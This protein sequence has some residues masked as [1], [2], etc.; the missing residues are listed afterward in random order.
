MLLTLDFDSDNPD[1]PV[2]GIRDFPEEG[3]S[4]LF[5]FDEGDTLNSLR[6]WAPGGGFSAVATG[7]TGQDA[8]SFLTNGGIHLQATSYVPLGPEID[9]T[10]PYTIF[11]HGS[12]DLPIQ[13]DGVTT[14]VSGMLSTDQYPARGFILYTT[15]GTSYPDDASGQ[16]LALRHTV[17]GVQQAPGGPWLI[18]GLTYLDP[19]TMA[20]RFDGTTA[21]LRVYR[22]GTL[23]ANFAQGI[24]V[25]GYTTNSSSVQDKTMRPV[26]GSPSTVFREGNLSAEISGVYTRALTDAELV[27]LDLAA[28]SLRHA[29]AR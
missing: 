12:N 18:A 5:F 28:T 24:N 9:F 15:R 29:R 2:A 23:L 8:A 7:G 19:L 1:L 13:H 6:N 22:A 25:T 26:L 21:T 4:G 14:W 16:S 27:D 3:L 20:V 17:N 11:W 10:L